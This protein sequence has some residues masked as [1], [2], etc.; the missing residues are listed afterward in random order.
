MKDV[1][2]YFIDFNI[3]VDAVIMFTENKIV[4]LIINRKKIIWLKDLTDTL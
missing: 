3:N 4:Q 1:N 2:G